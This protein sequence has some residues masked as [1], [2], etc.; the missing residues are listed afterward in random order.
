[1]G[2]N[3]IGSN[4]LEKAAE[5]VL[6]DLQ[7]KQFSIFDMLEAHKK[8]ARE[9]VDAAGGMMTH[10]FIFEILRE[11]AIDMASVLRDNLKEEEEDGR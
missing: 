11:H 3:E 10:G 7:K 2:K 8:V 9:F 5:R 4:D 1:M 6:E